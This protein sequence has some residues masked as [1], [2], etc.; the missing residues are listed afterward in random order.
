[1]SLV[2]LRLPY[3]GKEVGQGQVRPIEAKVTAIADFP[4]PATRKDNSADSWG[5]PVTT[6]VSVRIFHGGQPS[7]V[8]P[9][10]F[11]YFCMER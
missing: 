8:P 11:T 9:Q 10:P 2:K 1:M 5:W 6:G 4:V 7:D 3:L